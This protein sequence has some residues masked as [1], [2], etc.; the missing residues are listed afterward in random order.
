[1]TAPD[2][3][4]SDRRIQSLERGFEVLEY[5]YREGETT[6]SELAAALDLST[7]TA[8]IYLKT[9]S[10]LGYVKKAASKY[11]LSHRFL[12]LGTK[13]RKETDIYQAALS[14]VDKLADETNE[15]SA[16]GIPERG[17]RVLLYK[18]ESSEAVYDN[19]PAGE[20]THMHWTALGKAILGHLP[21]DQVEGII[22]QHGLPARTQ[23]T[24]TEESELF[25]EL[26]TINENGYA[27]EDEER[28][29]GIRSVAVP[30]FDNETVIGSI[31]VSGPKNRFDRD[32]I[33]S[34]LVTDLMQSKNVIEVR[35]AHE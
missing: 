13:T 35:L 26:A 28:W 10:D 23:Q 27:V 32:R 15:V 25:D 2:Q 22:D 7:S 3:G 8:H 29:N 5:L 12:R 31:S 17:K 6:V 11:S 16:L 24:I 21:R 4:T 14:E 9:L 19:P 30:I 20:Y 33:E 34:E 1:M 18:A